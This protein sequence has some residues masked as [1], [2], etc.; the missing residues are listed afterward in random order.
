[1]SG[2]KDTDHIFWLVLDAISSVAW[3]I[4]RSHRRRHHGSNFLTAIT[5]S[6]QSNSKLYVLKIITYRRPPPPPPPRLFHGPHALHVYHGFHGPNCFTVSTFCTY[7]DL[8][9]RMYLTSLLLR[10]AI[11]CELQR[12]S[13]TSKYYLEA[14]SFYSERKDWTNNRILHFVL[15]CGRNPTSFNDRWCVVDNDIVSIYGYYMVIY[16]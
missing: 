11:A 8:G 15:E 4:Y 14:A 3:L 10:G 6:S 16:N 9:S 1:M 12:H 13:L 2:E 7:T 5:Y